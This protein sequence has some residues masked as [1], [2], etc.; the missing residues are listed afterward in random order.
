MAGELCSARCSFCGRCDREGDANY[1][2]RILICAVCGERFTL[3]ADE[4]GTT[5][6]VCIDLNRDRR[7]DQNAA[8]FDT[9]VHNFFQKTER[10]T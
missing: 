4:Q 2:D 1:P 6:D 7:R 9:Y 8:M 5:C 10:T 3:P